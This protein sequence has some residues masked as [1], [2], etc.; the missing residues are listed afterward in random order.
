V[1]IETI[2]AAFVQAIHQQTRDMWATGEKAVAIS[3]TKGD[4]AGR[5]TGIRLI[6]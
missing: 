4:H 1:Q 3:V 6:D 2:G 5:F